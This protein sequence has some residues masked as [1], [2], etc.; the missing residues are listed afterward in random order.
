MTKTDAENLIDAICQL[1][2]EAAEM[3]D[4]DDIRPED[5]F[6]GIKCFFEN[7]EGA[8]SRA[9]ALDRTTIEYCRRFLETAEDGYYTAIEFFDID[10]DPLQDLAGYLKDRCRDGEAEQL[11]NVIDFVKEIR[12]WTNRQTDS[13]TT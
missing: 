7:N 2:S 12:R 11:Q 1:S 8:P 3:L 5:V 9:I 13:F 10:I 4:S 6:S